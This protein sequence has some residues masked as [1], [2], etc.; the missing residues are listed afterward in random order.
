M[1]IPELEARMRQWIAADY[2]A[3]LFEQ[4]PTVVAYALY[5]E[6][7]DLCICASSSFNPP[8][9]SAASASSA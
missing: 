7:K 8:R 1:S 5:R 3:I 6:D 4:D 9:A 2:R